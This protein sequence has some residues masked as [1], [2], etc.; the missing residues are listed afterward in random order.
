MNLWG[1]SLQVGTGKKE[2][3]RRPRVP[4]AGR[5]VAQGLLQDGRETCVFESSYAVILAKGLALRHT[6]EARI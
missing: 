4:E 2:R 5:V 3:L 6:K 1:F